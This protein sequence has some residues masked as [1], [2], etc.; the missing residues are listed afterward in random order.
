MTNC[1]YR[2][3]SFFDA[4]Y[5]GRYFSTFL[6]EL[7]LQEPDIFAKIF[8]LE[9]EQKKRL[10]KQQLQVEL[11]WFFP[12]QH[13]KKRSADLAVLDGGEAILLIEVKEDDINNSENAAQLNDYLS[14]ISSSSNRCSFAHVSRYAPKQ[15]E[16]RAI[17]LQ[18]NAKSYSYRDVY[19][20]LPNKGFSK[21][22]ADY[23]KDIG[24]AKY[25]TI[26][27]VKHQKEVSFFLAQ[28]LGFPHVNGLGRLYSNNAA[29]VVP[30]IIK[31]M[32]GNAEVLGDWLKSSNRDLLRQKSTRKFFPI[33]YYDLNA[34]GKE[35]AKKKTAQ[36]SELQISPAL[37]TGGYVRFFFSNM[38]GHGS[39]E[40]EKGNGLCVRV[41]FDL[42]L[43][44]NPKDKESP[45]EFWMYAEFSGNKLKSVSEFKQLKGFPT[46]HQAMKH[47]GDLLRKAL[48]KA[49]ESGEDQNKSL[50]EFVVP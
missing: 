1:F 48:Q 6:R 8:Q 12:G 30:E 7:A 36:A 49:I 2:I 27:L 39:N 42:G 19:S 50:R 43:M 23:L 11:E 45:I 24:V 5:S 26:D 13:K 16:L 35:V 47:A 38:I 41:G 10:I 33:Q 31:T 46:E 40:D 44:K 32:Y 17:D 15:S 18:D 25:E 20:A 34:L 28:A 9:S 14:L 21:M 29:T 22:L 4:K 37:I 3:R